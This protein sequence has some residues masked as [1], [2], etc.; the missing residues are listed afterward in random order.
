MNTENPNKKN[1]IELREK[2]LSYGSIAKL[3]NLSRARIH[4]ICSKYESPN[5]GSFVKKNI[6]KKIFVRDNFDCQLKILCKDKN[7]LIKDLVIH[8]IDFNDENNNVNNLVTLCR[9]CHAGFHATNHIDERYRKNVLEQHKKKIKICSNCGKEFWFKKHRKTCSDKCS[10]ERI[11]RKRVSPEE[12]YRKYRET[13]KKWYDLH[14]NTPEF[15]QKTKERNK[16][17]YL[18]KKQVAS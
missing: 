1:I 15:K 4:Q 7:I 2:G 16:R 14:K 12:R 17:Y 11:R 3:F 6:Y 13:I 8:H 9:F 5:H 18:M 10:T